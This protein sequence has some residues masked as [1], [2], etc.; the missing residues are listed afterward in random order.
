MVIYF[1]LANFPFLLLS[2]IFSNL[3]SSIPPFFFL[4][5]HRLSFL[6]IFRCLLSCCYLLSFNFFSLSPF[7]S[8]SFI[9]ILSSS[10]P[11]FFSPLF[12]S[13]FLPLFSILLLFTFPSLLFPFFF[14]FSIFFFLFYFFFFHASLFFLSFLFVFPSRFIFRYLLTCYDLLYSFSR[15]PYFHPSL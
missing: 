1:P 15:S 5:S 6:S 8:Q 14:F 11:P 10:M 7:S 9:S 4:F 2:L 13:S 3:S 12:P